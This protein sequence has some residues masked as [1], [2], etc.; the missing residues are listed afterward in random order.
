MVLSTSEKQ[1]SFQEGWCENGSVRLHYVESG[2]DSPTNLTPV[3]YVHSG[4]GTAEVFI[5]EMKALSPRRCVS[6]SL[7]GR[8]NSDAPEAGYSF[9]EN[10]SDLDA[11]VN[12]LALDRICVM[13]W[14]LGVTYSIAYTAQHPELVSGLI[15]LD[16]PARH[17]KFSA[18]WAERWSSDPSVK[19]NPDRMRG[20]RGLER[21]SSEILL[22]DKLD[23]IESPI[24]LIGGGAEGALLTQE[25]VERYRQHCRNLEVAIFPDSGHMV[26]QPDYD[27][28]ISTI[29][30]FLDYVDDQRGREI[31][32]A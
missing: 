10:V 12:H 16:Y 26:W 25:Y 1:F 4:F 3:V 8:G 2:W 20:M 31:P 27:R 11:V 22:W 6:C 13:G 15:L 32:G 28:L 30:K 21:D 5:P 24:L 14:S 18:G 9:D 19:D 7:R 17:P 23:A 29:N